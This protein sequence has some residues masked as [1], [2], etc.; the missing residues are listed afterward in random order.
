MANYSFTASTDTATITPKINTLKT[1]M[2]LRKPIW[3]KLT[4]AKKK[5]WILS[6]K[7]PIMGLAWSIYKY[8][9][10][11]FGGINPADVS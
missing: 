1:D 10:D 6:P 3:N 8:L 2:N 4:F 5:F 9:Y 11:F 7:D